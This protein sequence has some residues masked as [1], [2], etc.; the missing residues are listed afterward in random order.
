MK[1]TE[2]P[3]YETRNLSTVRELLESSVLLYENNI[4][5]LRKSNDEVEEIDYKRVFSDVIALSTYLN[6]IGLEGKKIAV[7]GKNS[8]EWS[9]AYLAVTCG[10]GIIVPFD[11]ELKKEELS[12]LAKDSE[13]SAIIYSNDSEIKLCGIEENILRLPM[14]SFEEYIQ[15]GNELISEGNTSYHNHKIDPNALG[16]L[17]YTSGTTGLA[18]GV[19]LSQ[20]NIVSDILGILNCVELRSD[21]RTLSLLPLHHTYQAT[22]GFLCFIYAGASVAFNDSLRRL[23]EDLVTYQPTV[24]IAVPALLEAFL[25]S[26]KKKYSTI[27]AGNT[28]YKTQKAIAGI[29]KNNAPSISK[30]IFK[31]V[32]TAFGGKM[33]AII[34]GAASLSPEIFNEYESFG[35]KVYIGYGLTETSPVSIMHNDAYSSPNDIGYPLKGIQTKLVD[36]NDEGVG[37]LALKGDNVMLGYYK[38][39]EVTEKVLR[40]GWFYTGDLARLNPN[41]TYSITGRAKSMIVIGNGKKVFPEELEFYLEQSDLV[42]E[43]LVYGAE[44]DG[45]IQVTA[46]I[47]PDYDAFKASCGKHAPE[48]DTPEYY[49]AIT[50]AMSK[51][52]R[53]INR[54]VPSFKCIRKI[55]IK[56]TE[57]EKTTTRKIKRV[58]E[59]NYSE[60]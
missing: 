7:I 12:Y 53:E 40:D 54:K 18:K 30:G 36:I 46:I 58:S 1:K 55:I 42:K 49:T 10:T 29:F 6:S 60:E 5:Y 27:F 13:I 39:P 26:V 59:A 32:N 45:D 28:I 2:I 38:N 19:M 43:C 37:E 15:K 48:K 35:I 11:K 16:V 41:G 3:N 4:A 31:S 17:I 14:D 21:D 20:Y 33:R 47:Y 50:E 56:K 52:V 23:Q 24:F 22:A 57:F 8:Y 51:L 9:I 25:K 34:C 44:K